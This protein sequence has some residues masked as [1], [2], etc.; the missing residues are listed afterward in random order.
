MTPAP[1]G[2]VDFAA[3]AR[4]QGS[5]EEVARMRYS[6]TLELQQVDVE[7]VQLWGDSSTAVLRPLVPV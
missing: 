6:A 2:Q 1:W 4:S 5:W 7:G 3:L